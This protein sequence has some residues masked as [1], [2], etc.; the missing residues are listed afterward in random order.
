MVLSPFI[1]DS[2]L[3]GK[4]DNEYCVKYNLLY[5]RIVITKIAMPWN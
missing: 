1:T 4:I 3:V 2:I 5:C